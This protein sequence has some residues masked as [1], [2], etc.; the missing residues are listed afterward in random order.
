MNEAPRLDAR[1]AKLDLR[2]VIVGCI[3]I[4]FA[5][6]AL[7]YPHGPQAGSK[8]RPASVPARQEQAPSTRPNTSLDPVLVSCIVSS[9]PAAG[10]SS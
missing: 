4:A 8:R 2:L 7:L 10:R 3:A 6:A 1:P 9:R 5:A